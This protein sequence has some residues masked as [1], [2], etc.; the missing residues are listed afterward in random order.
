MK[1][2]KINFFYIYFA[3]SNSEIQKEIKGHKSFI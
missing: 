3:N 2:F 1:P